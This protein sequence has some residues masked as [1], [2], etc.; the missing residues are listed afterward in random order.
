MS[1]PVHSVLPEDAGQA[2]LIGRVWDPETG[3]PRVVAVSGGTV[4]DLHRLAGTV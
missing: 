3:G 4:F 2:L 1:L